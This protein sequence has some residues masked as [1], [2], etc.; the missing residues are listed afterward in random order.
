M[1]RDRISGN[2]RSIACL[3]DAGSCASERTV[4]RS[5]SRMMI[6]VAPA[7]SPSGYPLT[8]PTAGATSSAVTVHRGLTTNQ[9]DNDR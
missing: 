8:Q 6:A 7:R 4:S 9:N 3:A 5:P 2:K 1:I